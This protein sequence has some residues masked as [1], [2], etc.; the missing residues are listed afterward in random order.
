[1]AKENPSP[2]FLPPD[3][4]NAKVTCTVCGK[5]NAPDLWKRYDEPFV[6][7]YPN[8]T[9]GEKGAWIQQAANVACDCG[10]G[11]LLSLKPVKP[12]GAFY[13]FGDEAYREFD[14]YHIVTFSLIG[15][16][17]SVVKKMADN[18]YGM[19]REFLPGI[20]PARWKIHATKLL[21][22]RDR[23]KKPAF[24]NLTKEEVD[25]SIEKCSTAIA[26]LAKYGCN[27]NVLAVYR[28]GNHPKK[29]HTKI[30]EEI[31]LS[32]WTALISYMIYET[33]GRGGQPF[34]TFDAQAPVR[35]YPHV[36]TWANDSFVGSKHYLAHA[37]LTHSTDVPTPT[38]AEPGSHPFQE[39]ADIHAYSVGRM[40]ERRVRRL[41]TD[42][43][44]KK[45][46]EFFYLSFKGDRVDHARSTDIP[47]SFLFAKHR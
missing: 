25:A 18:I 17:P 4:A 44:L 10:G 38:F 32:S 27:S 39:L 5:Q 7:I 28:L 41:A 13:L 6:P 45:F 26:Q 36:E 34:F 9:H 24:L 3:I 14:G 22:S 40:V 19:K 11:G 23:L 15:G 20:E 42:T 29:D 12:T 35:K 31:K 21:N 46:G 33:T 2:P 43:D 30:R 16:P 1:M 47:E 37:L 8:G